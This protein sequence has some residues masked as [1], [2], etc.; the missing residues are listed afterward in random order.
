MSELGGSCFIGVA[1]GSGWIQDSAQMYNHAGVH[2][3]KKK[4]HYKSKIRLSFFNFS[5]GQTI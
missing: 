4:L 5:N 1:K 3:K 2:K